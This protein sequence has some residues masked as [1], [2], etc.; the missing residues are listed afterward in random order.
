ME[1]HARSGGGRTRTRSESRSSQRT[2]FLSWL[3]RIPFD[4]IRRRRR[5][6]GQGGKGKEF[7]SG[8]RSRGACGN[9]EAM[10]RARVAFACRNWHRVGA[11][12]R[13]RF[14]PAPTPT[15]LRKCLSFSAHVSFSARGWLVTNVCLRK[16]HCMFTFLWQQ[17]GTDRLTFKLPRIY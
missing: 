6:Q 5:V 16:T 10:A 17:V 7:E 13:T 14:V 1:A 12:R 15:D 3:A 11:G 4:F 9:R 8:T 2:L